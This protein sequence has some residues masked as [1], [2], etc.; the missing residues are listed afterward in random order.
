MNNDVHWMQKALSLAH[1]AEAI[2]EVPIG[3]ILV[4]DGKIIG[5]GGSTIAEISQAHYCKLEFRRI[6]AAHNGDTPLVIKSLRGKYNDILAAENMVDNIVS[7]P[8]FT[9]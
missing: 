4:K 2:G 5:R 7:I 1:K 6:E 3:A 8:P 9:I